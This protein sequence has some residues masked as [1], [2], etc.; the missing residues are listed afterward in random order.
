MRYGCQIWSQNQ[1]KASEIIEK[2]INTTLKIISFK[3][4]RKEADK[5]Y[6]ETQ[7]NK[8]KLIFH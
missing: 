8:C 7:I 5:L 4:I 3:N 2:A 6:K 1:H